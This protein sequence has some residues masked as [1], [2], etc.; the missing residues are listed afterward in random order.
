[1]FVAWLDVFFSLVFRTKKERWLL[2]IQYTF[3]SL[4]C[5]E[6]GL[7]PP[8]AVHLR[9]DPPPPRWYWHVN[10]FQRLSVLE[11]RPLQQ[12]PYNTTPS[13]VQVFFDNNKKAVS[14]EKNHFNREEAGGETLHF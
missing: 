14:H 3:G 10:H 8:T 6:S 7:P 9:R 2:S 5:Q 4:S 1:M 13:I 12:W 11:G